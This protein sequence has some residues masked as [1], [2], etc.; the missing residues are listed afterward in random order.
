MRGCGGF[1]DLATVGKADFIGF[2]V[3][4]E[5]VKTETAGIC[6]LRLRGKTRDRNTGRTF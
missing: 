5:T 6:R 1:A 2:R 4:V 3:A